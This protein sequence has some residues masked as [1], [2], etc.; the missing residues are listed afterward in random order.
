MHEL[1][2]ASGIV[3]HVLQFTEERGIRTVLAVRLAVGEL[4]AVHRDQLQFCYDS[5][6]RDTP[7][8]N[9][10]LMFETMKPLV[11]CRSC[12]YTGSPK[13]WEDAIHG[14]PV[15]TTQCPECG[16]IAETVQGWECAVKGITYVA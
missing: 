5:I 3:E 9:S 14:I 10:E 8:E 12:S 16:S 2:I 13:F 1:S 15:A 4:A 11:S 6:T 7:L